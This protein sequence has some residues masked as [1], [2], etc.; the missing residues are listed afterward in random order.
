MVGAHTAGVV[1]VER[2]PLVRWEGCVGFEELPFG[3]GEVARVNAMV[4]K[5]HNNAR[6]AAVQYRDLCLRATRIVTSPLDAD[7]WNSHCGKVMK[8]GAIN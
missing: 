3:F 1:D 5:R 6:A 4:A 2:P 8:L 7:N